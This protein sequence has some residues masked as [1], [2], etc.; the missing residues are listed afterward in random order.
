[1]VAVDRSQQISSGYL[2]TGIEDPEQAKSEV[3]VCCAAHREEFE[4][5]GRD[6]IFCFPMRLRVSMCDV[7]AKFYW[8]ITII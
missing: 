4:R 2:S 7:R 3:R 1:M 6:D 5:I 8:T